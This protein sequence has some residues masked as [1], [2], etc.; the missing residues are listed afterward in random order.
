MK[1]LAILF[2]LI[3]LIMAGVFWGVQQNAKKFIPF[4]ACIEH[5]HHVVKTIEEAFSYKSEFGCET[6]KVE[7]IWR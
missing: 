4:L 7:M 6:W 5:K 2:G 3:L 1:S